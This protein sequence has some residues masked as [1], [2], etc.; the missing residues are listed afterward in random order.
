LYGKKSVLDTKEKE[1]GMVLSK[2]I[3]EEMVEI[4]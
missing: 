1:R 2:T 3:E 4:L